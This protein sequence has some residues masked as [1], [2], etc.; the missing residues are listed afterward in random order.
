MASLTLRNID[1]SLKASLRMSAAEHNRSM[2]EEA[3]QILKQFLLRKRSSVG[4]GS[5]ISK[6]F[7]V[8]GGADLP[9][10]HRS[11]PRRPP[12]FFSDDA[13]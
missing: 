1:E 6:R 4:I 2:E 8:I 5:C 3:R 11:G 13:Q 10:V 7:S 12:A 9:D